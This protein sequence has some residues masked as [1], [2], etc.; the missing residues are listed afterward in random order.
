M[1]RVSLKMLC[2]EM[3]N[4]YIIIWVESMCAI[5]CMSGDLYMFI[6]VLILWVHYVSRGGTK[7]VY[8][9]ILWDTS[10]L[11]VNTENWRFS[12][13]ECVDVCVYM[14]ECKP[15]DDLLISQVGC[16]KRV[17][18]FVKIT[19]PDMIIFWMVMWKF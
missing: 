6:Y 4:V 16:G 17:F 15:I 13:R 11:Y 14:K 2:E 5:K 8:I 18:I 3:L 19:S 9:H 1:R 12:R 10:A 7:Y